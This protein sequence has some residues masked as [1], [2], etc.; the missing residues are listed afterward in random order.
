[1]HGVSFAQ[2]LTLLLIAL[3]FASLALAAAPPQQAQGEPPPFN[4]EDC[5]FEEG[6]TICEIVETS[7]EA[8]AAGAARAYRT[9]EHCADGT[10]LYEVRKPVQQVITTTRVVF[11]GSS[12]RIE[13]YEV[14]TEWLDGYVVLDTRCR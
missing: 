2:R 8:Q 10:T 3:T 11:Y 13:S 9:D 5:V 4:E 12:H 7:D 6:R 14:F 1:M